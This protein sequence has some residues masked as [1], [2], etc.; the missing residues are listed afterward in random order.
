MTNEACS[1]YVVRYTPGAVSNF[2]DN[3]INTHRGY[4]GRNGVAPR[5]DS[6]VKTEKLTG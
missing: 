6:L 5:V 2:L 3:G 1:K 4:L